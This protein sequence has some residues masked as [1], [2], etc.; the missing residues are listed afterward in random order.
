MVSAGYSVP[1]AEGGKDFGKLIIN[2]W[3]SASVPNMPDAAQFVA[4]VWQEELG[5][6]AEVTVSEESAIKKLTRLTETPMDRFC[7]GT[8]R[9]GWTAP[10]C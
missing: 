9:P 6:D 4:E 10:A 3:P 1:G 8:T 2:T 7:S 5:I